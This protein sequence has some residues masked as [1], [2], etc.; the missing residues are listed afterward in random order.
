MLMADLPDTDPYFVEAIFTVAISS[1]LTLQAV[2]CSIIFPRMNKK[3]IDCQNLKI[4]TKIAC[5]QALGK[6]CY[7]QDTMKSWLRRR[8]LVLS[9]V[10]R[11]FSM[12]Q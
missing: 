6:C 1:F 7:L 4:T 5:F 10:V 9:V 12:T 11:V 3:E 8:E 2:R